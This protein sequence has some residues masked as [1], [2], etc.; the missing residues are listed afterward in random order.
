MQG[1]LSL[2]CELV[3]LGLEQ[4]S[5]STLQVG[6]QS[7]GRTVQARG[8]KQAAP[9]NC[10]GEACFLQ[11]TVTEK[12]SASIS[13]CFERYRNYASALDKGSAPPTAMGATIST[14]SRLVEDSRRITS[15]LQALCSFRAKVSGL[16]SQ[17]WIRSKH[18]LMGPGT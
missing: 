4:P 3:G 9:K 8:H 14:P 13:S 16:V 5:F 7:N 10:S 17:R 15:P 6:L 2:G 11:V 18:Y 1:R 12:T